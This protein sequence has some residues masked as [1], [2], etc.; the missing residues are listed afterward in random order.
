MNGVGLSK[1]AFD[2]IANGVP[3]AACLA[4]FTLRLVGRGF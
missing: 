1:I 2:V 3:E 4:L